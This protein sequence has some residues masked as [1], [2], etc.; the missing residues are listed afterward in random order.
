M[1]LRMPGVDGVAATAR[2]AAGEAGTPAP[3]VLILT[4]YETDE[5]ILA[6]VEAGAGGYLLKAAPRAEI[7]A[8]IRS[9]AAGQSAL[10]PQVAVRLVERMR[11]PAAEPVLTPREL[12][13][14]RRVA[15]GRSNRQIGVDLGIG[16]AT[17]KTHLQKAF[18]KLDAPD[19][20]RAVTRAM[21]LGLLP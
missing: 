2:L 8:A 5:Q 20:T 17:V 12:D 3:R 11:R 16:E 21:E 1:D 9:V 19:R 6:A 13:V 10:S 7:V 4:T 14:L 18:D 15:Q